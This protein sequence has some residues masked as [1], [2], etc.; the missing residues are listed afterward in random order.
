MNINGPG[1]SV[2]P[3]SAAINLGRESNTACQTPS[4]P[5]LRSHQ[6]ACIVRERPVDT[7]HLHYR[8]THQRLN[9]SEWPVRYYKLAGKKKGGDCSLAWFPLKFTTPLSWPWVNCS[10]IPQPPSPPCCKS[11]TAAEASDWLPV[12]AL[13]MQS[14]CPREPT[15]LPFLCPASHLPPSV[16]PAETLEMTWGLVF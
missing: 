11:F 6:I 2:V 12:K 7:V 14:C 15:F 8:C 16:P 10:D 5:S 13:S 1:V 3:V 4:A 9:V